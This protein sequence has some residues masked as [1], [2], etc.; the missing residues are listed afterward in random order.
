MTPPHLTPRLMSIAD[1]VCFKKL[2]D[3]GT[4]H[5]Y[6]PVYLCMSGK[7]DCAVASDIRIGPAERAKSTVLKYDLH[8]KIAVRVGP[9]LST[10]KNR[11][12]DCAV[13]AGM[14]GL[15]IAQILEQP[16][17][18]LTE[19]KQI[20]LQPM[21]AVAELREY[22]Y[23]NGFKIISE[24]LKKK[25]KKI[26]NIIEVC[27]DETIRTVP[28]PGKLYIGEYLIDNRPGYYDEYYHKKKSKLIKMIAGLEKSESNENLKKLEITKAL[29]NEIKSF[30]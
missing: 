2:A 14:G 27:F 1:M 29:L 19:L 6:L 22:L 11:E 24:A 28:S 13:I 23:K 3:I 26:Y 4:D 25:K 17:K 21:T 8:D 12:V 18:L 16:P 10:I 15:L 9:G 5:A 20:I 7:I 30:E